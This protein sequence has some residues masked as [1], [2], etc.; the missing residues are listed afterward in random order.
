[1]ASRLIEGEAILIVPPRREAHVLNETGSAAWALLD[2]TRT[3]GE[4]A[5]RLAER[6]E[7]GTDEAARDLDAFLDDLGRRGAVEPDGASPGTLA[8]EPVP[9]EPTRYAP[10]SVAE[11]HPMEVLAALCDSMRTGLPGGPGGGGGGK[12]P[13]KP[14]KCRADDTLCKKLFE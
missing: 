9:P 12:K 13:P 14:G 4:I 7:V 10:P 3:P 5:G 2:G 11:T 6:Y 1:M 8:P